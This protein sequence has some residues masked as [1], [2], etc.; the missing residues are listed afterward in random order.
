MCGEISNQ[1]H[2]L[3]L[4]PIQAQPDYPCD[5]K[6]TLRSVIFLKKRSQQSILLLSLT[7]SCWFAKV[8]IKSFVIHLLIYTGSA[9]SLI[10]REIFKNLG[11]CEETL[12]KV[13]TELK[14]ADGE[15]LQVHR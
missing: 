8:I 10:S 13:S 9:V 15:P 1:Q 3:P 5:G 6:S 7:G 14:T 11:M 2:A 12:R 4:R